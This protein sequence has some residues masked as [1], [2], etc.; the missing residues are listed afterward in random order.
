MKPDTAPTESEPDWAAPAAALR[1]VSPSTVTSDSVTVIQV[2]RTLSPSITAGPLMVIARL[3]VTSSWKVHAPRRRV[4]P[5]GVALIAPWRLEGH[6]NGLAVGVGA[7]VAATNDRKEIAASRATPDRKV[8]GS[9][10]HRKM[11]H[12]ARSHRLF[13]TLLTRP[14]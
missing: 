2:A 11:V 8:A 6:G 10:Q 3:T 12:G 13:R 4:P 1:M 7:G 9:G 5:V 14:R